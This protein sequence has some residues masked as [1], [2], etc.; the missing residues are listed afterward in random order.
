[1][2]PAI[3][4]LAAAFLVLGS[5]HALADGAEDGNRGLDALNQGDY[6]TA[7]SDF[8]SALNSGLGPEDREFAL[9]NRGR[10]YLHKANYS[11]AIADLDRARQMKPDD[12]DAQ[13]DL[14]TALQSR[15]PPDSIPDRPKANFFALLGLTLL[16]GLVTGLA[17]GIQQSNQQ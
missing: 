6:D 14:L 8:T 3:A 11:L 4:L 15:V 2:R 5:A 17:A 7:I 13:N 16:K 1:M 10:A 12:M 9:A